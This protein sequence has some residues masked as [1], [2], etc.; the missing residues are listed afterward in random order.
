MSFPLAQ[1]RDRLTVSQWLFTAWSLDPP[2][3]T[4]L[5]NNANYAALSRGGFGGTWFAKLYGSVK[6]LPWY[7]AHG[8]GTLYW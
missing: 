2:E 6:L 4:E 5:P 8:P 1:S 3:A 7:K